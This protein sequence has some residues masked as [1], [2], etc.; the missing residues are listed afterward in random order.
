M[1]A[2]MITPVTATARLVCQG[3]GAVWRSRIYEAARYRAEVEA[4]GPA[5]LAGWRVYIGA[6]SQWAYCPACG[7]KVPM[8]LVHGSARMGVA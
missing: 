7:P 6:R 3:C 5:F 2:I 4:C 8:R 1:A